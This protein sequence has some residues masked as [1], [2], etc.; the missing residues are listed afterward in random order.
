MFQVGQVYAVI[1]TF[2]KSL[3]AM[4]KVRLEAGRPVRN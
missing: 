2:G 3:V 4:W 1:H